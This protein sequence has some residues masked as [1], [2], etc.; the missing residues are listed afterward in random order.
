M[1][2]VSM[3]AVAPRRSERHYRP[4]SGAA[5]DPSSAARLGGGSSAVAAEPQFAVTARP[6]HTKN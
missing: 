3:A 4:V 1:H 6:L 5:A 2:C